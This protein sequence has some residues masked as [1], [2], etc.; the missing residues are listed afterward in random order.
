M[1]KKKITIEELAEITSKGFKEVG[2]QIDQID[3]KIDDKIDNLAQ[4]T[5]RGFEQVDK[6]FEQVDKRF[7]QVDKRFEK[8]EGD[9]EYMNARLSN[10]EKDTAEIRRHFVY[11]HEFEDLMARVK[12]LE[13]KLGVESGK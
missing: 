8:I 13:Q 6:R 10:V 5:A 9:L 7:E 3:K 12:Y 2:K 11:R 1:P 4:I